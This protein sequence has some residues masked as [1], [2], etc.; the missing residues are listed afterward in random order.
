MATDRLDSLKN[1]LYDVTEGV[2]GTPVIGPA[3][4]AGFAIVLLWV[5]KGVL[6]EHNIDVLGAVTIAY[7]VVHGFVTWR[8][9]ELTTRVDLATL[10]AYNQA[11]SLL[12]KDGALT[13]SEL[14]AAARLIKTP[15]PA[16][17]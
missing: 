14:A 12:N 6:T 11:I 8:K 3:I 5:T 17:P 13:E 4:V 2:K 16:A 15:A 10:T 1:T 9:D 7:L